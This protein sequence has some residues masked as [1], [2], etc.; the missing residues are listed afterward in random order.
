MRPIGLYLAHSW[1]PRREIG[2]GREEGSG[3]GR[4]RKVEINIGSQMS[5]TTPPTICIWYVN[6]MVNSTR[7]NYII[8]KLKLLVNLVEN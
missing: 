6:L 5:K 8:R 2:V 4:D 7:R 3:I 1:V